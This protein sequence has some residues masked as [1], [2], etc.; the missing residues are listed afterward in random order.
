MGILNAAEQEEAIRCKVANDNYVTYETNPQE[1]RDNYL[2][3]KAREAGEEAVEEFK[4][5]K[6]NYEFF[7]MFEGM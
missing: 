7:S 2:E 5:D 6:T 4:R 1:Y 3:V